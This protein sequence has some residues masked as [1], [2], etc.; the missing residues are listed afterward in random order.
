MAMAKNKGFFRR[1]FAGTWYLIGLIIA[2]VL[3]FLGV[4]MLTGHFEGLNQPE[5]VGTAPLNPGQTQDVAALSESFGLPL[6]TLPGYSMHGQALNV[7]YNGRNVRQAILQ[8]DGF[9]I[10]CVQPA[11]AAPLLLRSDL[12]LSLEEGITVDGLPAALSEKDTAFCLYFNTDD[13]AY[14]IFAPAAEK[15]SFLQLAEKIVFTE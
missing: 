9:T 12:S 4:L 6:P 11:F 14:S 5:T 13:A 8:Y 2:A 10:T 7:S 3:C 1:F 15:E